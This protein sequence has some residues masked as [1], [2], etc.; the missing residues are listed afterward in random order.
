MSLNINTKNSRYI[1]EKSSFLQVF[2]TISKCETGK[3]K[4]L[5]L[6]RKKSKAGED[7]DFFFPDCAA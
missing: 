7:A 1:Q 4:H 3:V 2:K 6:M 5:G